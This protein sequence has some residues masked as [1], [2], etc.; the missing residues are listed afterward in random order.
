M[1]QQSASENALFEEL[2]LMGLKP[3]RQYVVNKIRISLAFPNQKVAVE[4]D[5]PNGKTY[6]EKAADERKDIVLESLGWRIMRVNSRD[7]DADPTKAASDVEHFVGD[8]TETA[9][10]A[11]ET[12]KELQDIKASALAQTPAEVSKTK[13]EKPKKINLKEII[14][15]MQKIEK[16]KQSDF[17]Q[18]SAHKK[19]KAKKS[20]KRAKAKTKTEK[21]RAVKTARMPAKHHKIYVTDDVR[22]YTDA[23]MK[24]IVLA[25]T[26]IVLMILLLIYLL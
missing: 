25:G 10:D 18:K 8:E 26:A 12:A 13:T 4:I 3:E 23:S 7:I 1:S 21:K 24:K 11:D 14:P 17:R 9:E 2:S 16:P 22:G 15:G 5:G 19:T 6:E 20:A